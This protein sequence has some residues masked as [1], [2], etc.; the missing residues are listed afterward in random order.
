MEIDTKYKVLFVFLTFLLFGGGLFIGFKLVNKDTDNSLEILNDVKENIIYEEDEKSIQTFSKKYDIELVYEENYTLCNET[1]SKREIIYGTTLDELKE[2][3]K[4]KQEKQG[5]VYMIKEESNDRL[6]Y[7]RNIS[8]NC[9]NHFKVILEDS[10]INIYR[11]VDE[12]NQEL[13]RKID[14]KDKL[15][16]ED[17]KKELSNGITINSYEDLNLLIEDLES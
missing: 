4:N 7:Y 6:V 5:K 13:Y 12:N 16:R 1:V 15:I 2:N 14:T 9:P 10:V 3:E 11:V 17:I 8:T